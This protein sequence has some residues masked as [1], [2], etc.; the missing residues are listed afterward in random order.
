MPDTASRAPAPTCAVYDAHGRLLRSMSVRRH[1]WRL[2]GHPNGWPGHVVDHVMPLC[3]CG[4]DAVE[5]MQWQ[6]LADSRRKDQWERALCAGKTT[7]G[8]P[9]WCAQHFKEDACR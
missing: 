4:K 8:W 7:L 5:N 9:Q 6:P 1:F 2:T 3:A